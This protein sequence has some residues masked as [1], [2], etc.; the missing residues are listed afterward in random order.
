MSPLLRTRLQVIIAC[1]AVWVA[2]IA[3]RFY[4]LQVVR[5][6]HYAGKAGR[7]QG[8]PPR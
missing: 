3:G 7:Q 8:Q 5:H 4:Q 2:L 1:G 6:E